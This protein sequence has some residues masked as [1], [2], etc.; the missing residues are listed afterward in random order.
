M[1]SWQPY[2]DLFL[3]GPE[4]EWPHITGADRQILVDWQTPVKCVVLMI[5]DKIL[6]VL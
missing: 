3:T 2:G 4:F 6:K 5:V 1:S